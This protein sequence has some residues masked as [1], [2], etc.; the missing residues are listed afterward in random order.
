MRMDSGRFNIRRK[1]GLLVVLMASFFKLPVFD[2]VPF[3]DLLF[4]GLR[5][6]SAW[7]VLCVYLRQN[8][9][10]PAFFFYLCLH[11]SLLVSTLLRGRSFYSL[12]AE[13]LM[14]IA[15]FAFFS[16]LAYKP[17]EW[18][19][20]LFP[21]SEIL[22]YSNLAAII[23]FPGGLYR[24]AFTNY[25]NCWILGYKNLAISFY[26]CFM[27]VAALYIRYERPTWRAW[28]L[29]FG[30]LL[31]SITS[32]ASSNIVVVSI[33]IILMVLIQRGKYKYLNV[34]SLTAVNALLFSTRGSNHCGCPERI[35]HSLGTNPDMGCSF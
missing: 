8:K 14:Q 17:R 27:L 12:I 32:K 22:T 1:A 11:A 33:F 5:I 34:V 10:S 23:L 16:M 2:A 15:V 29:L 6:V 25:H 28:A 26:L 9:I 18:L 7:V 20:I 19:R 13:N 3:L 24:S 30:I 21:V 35:N 31:C 4:N